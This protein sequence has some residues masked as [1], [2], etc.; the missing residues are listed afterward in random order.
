[1]KIPPTIRTKES[2]KI[3][4]EI[5]TNWEL[6]ESML[7]L[8]TIA[9]ESYQRLQQAKA[10][11]DKTGLIIKTPSGQVKKH[12]ALEAEKVARQGFLMAWR[13]LNL[14]IE[15]PG[16]VGRPAGRGGFSQCLR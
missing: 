12:P 8:L 3:W 9:L 15:A 6:D 4:K 10:I 7:I 16:A 11:L 5:T 1:L 2:K 14:G 13:M